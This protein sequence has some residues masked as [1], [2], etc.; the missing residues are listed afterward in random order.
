MTKPHDPRPDNGGNHPDSDVVVRS[1]ERKTVACS[2]SGRRKNTGVHR[3]TNT[4]PVRG[5]NAI[6]ARMGKKCPTGS[7]A[8]EGAIQECEAQMTTAMF[9][10]ATEQGTHM[11]TTCSLGRIPLRVPTGLISLQGVAQPVLVGERVAE[12]WKRHDTPNG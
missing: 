10:K 3:R 1:G 9:A 11:L 12:F 4:L 2:P 8:V 5:R 6:I 7:C